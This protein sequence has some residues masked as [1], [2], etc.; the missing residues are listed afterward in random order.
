MND[1]WYWDL[2]QEPSLRRW[3]CI[4]IGSKIDSYLFGSSLSLG[5]AVRVHVHACVHV[6]GSWAFSGLL[7]SCH[8]EPPLFFF[9]LVYWGGMSGWNGEGLH[10]ESP[11]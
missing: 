3:W 11:W 6:M 1:T 10:G 4:K 2:R 5:S 9:F 7:C 8:S